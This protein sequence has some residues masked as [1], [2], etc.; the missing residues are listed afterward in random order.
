MSLPRVV[1]L[2]AVVLG[3]GGAPPPDE[4][5]PDAAPPATPQ[6][7]PQARP[8]SPSTAS[9]IGVPPGHLP[10]V[11]YCRVWIPGT[12]PGRQPGQKSRRCQGI[13]AE[14]PAGSWILHR[15]STDPK[16]LHVRVVDSRRSGVVIRVRVYEADTGKFLREEAP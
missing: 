15:P 4:P 9:T 14:A 11:G 5:S 16:L 7:V 8:G 3:C 2:T 10:A 1:A 12:P 13:G 6:A